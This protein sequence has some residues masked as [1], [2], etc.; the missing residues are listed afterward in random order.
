M[1]RKRLSNEEIRR[2]YCRWCSIY[3]EPMEN[4]TEEM[5]DCVKCYRGLH[6]GK[7]VDDIIK[8]YRFG[9]SL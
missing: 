9:K 1:D 3:N 6:E 2:D 5:S 4:T 8:K 7:N